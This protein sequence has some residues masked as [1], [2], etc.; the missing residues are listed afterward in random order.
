MKVLLLLST[1][2]CQTSFNCNYSWIK[3]E[4]KKTFPLHQLYCTVCDT[5]F[6]TAEQPIERNGDKPH[7]K[8]QLSC[9]VEQY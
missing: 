5:H 1:G 4:F 6:V 2:I 8:R 3:T 7:C 9:I